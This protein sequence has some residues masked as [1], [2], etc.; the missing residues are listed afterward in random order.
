MR[1]NVLSDGQAV[2]GWNSQD[3]VLTCWKKEDR[4]QVWVDW[5]DVLWDREGLASFE[6]EGHRCHK[7]RDGSDILRIRC[8]MTSWEHLE[9][10]SPRARESQRQAQRHEEPASKPTMKSWHSLNKDLS[11]SHACPFAVKIVSLEEFVI[12]QPDLATFW[13]LTRKRTF[14][15]DHWEKTLRF[16][17]VWTQRGLLTLLHFESL[18][19]VK[20][21]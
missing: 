18:C 14:D 20:K 5:K 1:T 11:L 9:M 10:G 2:Q 21:I 15:W 7:R 17:P 4:E 3:I 6:K 12:N 19:A 16:L 8:H 13:P